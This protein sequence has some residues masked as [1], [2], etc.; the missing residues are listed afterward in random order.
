MPAG[1]AAGLVRIPDDSRSR[2]GRSRART[3]ASLSHPGIAGI[4][5]LEEA[6][7]KRYLELEYVDGEILDSRLARGAPPVDD[8]LDIAG[9]I[10]GGCSCAG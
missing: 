9:R 2:P 6:D 4:Y 3:L 1:Y 8:A 7:G 5:G 10:A